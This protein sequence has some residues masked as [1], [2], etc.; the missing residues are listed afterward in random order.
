[1]L[2]V[3]ADLAGVAVGDFFPQPSP[4]V[5]V[6]SIGKTWLLAK[7]VF[8]KWWLTPGVRDAAC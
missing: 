2:K 6:K 4:D 8:E 3:R 1:M 5:Q 7:A